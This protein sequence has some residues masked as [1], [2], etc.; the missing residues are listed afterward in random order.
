IIKVAGVCGKTA[1]AVREARI[2]RDAGYDIGL[3]SLAALP[4]ATDCELIE[5]CRA[6]AREISL[7][8][9]YLQ[10]S[11]G[12]RLLSYDFWRGFCD[13]E[14]SAAVKVAAF[15]R[16]Q[17]LDVVRAVA[18]SGRKD[19]ALYTGNDDNIVADLLGDF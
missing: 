19:I 1:Q 16:Y 4:T 10:P 8:G 14:N 3:L 11:V 12:G 15:N 13:I 7:F 5:H 2:A 17:T 18:A 9:F 6:V